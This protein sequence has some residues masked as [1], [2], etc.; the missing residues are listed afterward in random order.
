MR[1]L[2]FILFTVSTQS[3]KI[4][5]QMFSS[6]GGYKILSDTSILKHTIGQQSIAGNYSTGNLTF[7]QGFQQANL[8]KYVFIEDTKNVQTTLYP[9]P[10]DELVNFNISI[11]ILEEITVSIYEHS[12][13]L[14]FTTRKKPVDNVLTIELPGLKEGNFLVTLNANNY[15]YTTKI[16]KKQ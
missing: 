12:G 15:N 16:I 4:H 2:L 1:L 14:I 3:Q 10:F 9:N 8:S 6:S 5:H 7:G 11:T 13:K